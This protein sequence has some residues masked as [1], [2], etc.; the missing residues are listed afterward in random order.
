MD[1]TTQIHSCH[2]STRQISQFSIHF[3]RSRLFSFEICQIAFKMLTNIVVLTLN[4]VSI[5][6]AISHTD[7]R[8]FIGLC[9]DFAYMRLIEN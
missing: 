4:L 3:Q 5:I 7:T 8:R 2:G 1:L 9:I 6:G